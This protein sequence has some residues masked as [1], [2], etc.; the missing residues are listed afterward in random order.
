MFAVL[1]KPEIKN[2]EEIQKRIDDMGP[3]DSAFE[4]I[5]IIEKRI[6]PLQE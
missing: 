6:L 2:G 5:Q 1:E 3:G 4:L